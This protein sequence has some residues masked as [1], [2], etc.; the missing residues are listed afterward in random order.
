[1][2]SPASKVHEAGEPD[3]VARDDRV[4]GV[5][6]ELVE[7]RLGRRGGEGGVD[8]G[9]RRVALHDGGEVGDGAGRHRHAQRVAVEVP[10][11]GGQHQPGGPG[12]PGR[13]R[14]DVGRRR[15]CPPQ[16]LV[17]QVEQVLVVGVGVHGRHEPADDVELVVDH[18]DHGDEAVRRARRVRDDDV[19]LGVVVLVVDADHEGGVGVAGRGRD[20]DPLHRPAQVPGGVLPAGEDPGGLDH[21]VGLEQVPGQLRRVRSAMTRMGFSPTSRSLPSTWTGTDSRPWVES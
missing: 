6:E 16:V 19:L 1:M 3:D 11:H 18:L 9:D 2:V 5:D 12:R 17:R 21:D 15:P 10:L 14:H 13:G 8:L 4:L 20:D 7:G